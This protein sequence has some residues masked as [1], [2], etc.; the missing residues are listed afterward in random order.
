MEPKLISMRV[1]HLS[2][3][4]LVYSNQKDNILF[5]TVINLSGRNSI[6]GIF[7][8]RQYFLINQAL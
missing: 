2:L 4:A 3:L 7:N 6:I 8:V 5:K 1:E